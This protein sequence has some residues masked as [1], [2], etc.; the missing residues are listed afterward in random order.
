MTIARTVLFHRFGGPEVL[1]IE[2]TD[3]RAPGPEE[4][5]IQTRALGINRAESMY[6]EGEYG[7][8]PTYP[9]AIGYEAAGVIESVGPGVTGFSVGDAVSVLPVLPLTDYAVHGELVIASTRALVRHPSNLSWE[10]A[11]AAWMQYI[12]AY[13]ALIDI[14]KVG[15]GDAVVITAAS[16]S[17]GLAAIQL[18]R[19]A[20]AMPIA[21]TRSSSKA[22]KLF[23]AGAAH[24]IATSEED[25]VA[26][27][28][29]ITDGGARVTFDPVGGE[30]FALLAQAAPPGG[31]MFIYG[32]LSGSVIQLPILPV[33][34]KHLTVRGYDLFEIAANPQRFA[35]AIADIS[36]GLSDGSLKPIIARRFPF[37]DFVEAHRYLESNQQFGKVVVTV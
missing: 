21:L 11:A 29:L 6:R 4:V 16:S 37:D 17:V 13:G 3:I 7:I 18:A 12:T 5:R 9:A 27:I 26:R 22:D 15:A 35:R 14:A 34:S 19:R 25:M 32:A 31:L 20:G 30:S 23:D 24:V 1:Q 36:E 28:Q 8:T 2:P 33:L 10:E